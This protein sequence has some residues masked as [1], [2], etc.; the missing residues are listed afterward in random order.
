VPVERRVSHTDFGLAVEY[1]MPFAVQDVQTKHPS[2]RIIHSEGDCYH[3][4]NR[5]AQT[6]MRMAVD[7][8]GYLARHDGVYTR[9][10]KDPA[11]GI[12]MGNGR[13]VAL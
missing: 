6:I 9:P 10:V 3:G 1:F 2:L 4:E 12:A 7:Y 8:S 11:N 13:V 5:S